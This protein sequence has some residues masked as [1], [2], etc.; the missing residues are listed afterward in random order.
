MITFIC[1]LKIDNV[2]IVKVIQANNHNELRKTIKT[3]YKNAKIV[4]T[5]DQQRV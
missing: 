3:N 2:I 4:S 1:R 5:R